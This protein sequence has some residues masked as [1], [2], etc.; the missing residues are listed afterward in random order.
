MI[1]FVVVHGRNHAGFCKGMCCLWR[2]RASRM[3]VWQGQASDIP[4][5]GTATICH[6]WSLTTGLLL[7]L[8][9][10]PVCQNFISLNDV[11]VFIMLQ[12]FVINFCLDICWWEDLWVFCWVIGCC[13]CSGVLPNLWRWWSSNHWLPTEAFWHWSW[14]GLYFWGDVLFPAL[15]QGVTEPAT[16]CCH[17]SQLSYFYTVFDFCF[18]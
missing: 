6:R 16:D 8:C 13:M 9:I 14:A 2:N 5:K 12:N 7:L 18:L 10:R 3:A 11:S 15:V 4:V 17:V 1:Y